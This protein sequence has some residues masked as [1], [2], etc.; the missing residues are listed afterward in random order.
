LKK[1]SLW[2][3]AALML[4]LVLIFPGIILADV[5]KQTK[6]SLEKLLLGKEVKP[7]VE[8]PATKEGLD[9]YIV[10][11]H[12][13][14]VDDR[15]VDL[16]AMSKELKS[17]GVGVEAQQWET[18]TD[19]KVDGDHIEIHLGGGGEGRRGANHANKVGA[20]YLRAGGSRVNF[21]YMAN[22]T[23]RDLQPEAFLNF[24][25]RVLDVSKVQSEESAKG[26][27]TEIRTAIAA[28]TVVEGMTYQMVQMSFGDPEQK[29]INDTTDSTF[30]ETWFYLRNG[31]RW[32]LTFVNGS[33][34]KVQVY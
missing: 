23:D 19:V 33:V 30:S 6:D 14:R 4:I 28:K 15:G 26:F 11:P 13:K 7:L 2:Q 21:R 32:V 1:V 29:K 18:I 17:K 9:V 16:G 5:S 34:G 24:M 8:L 10:P 20:G 3:F 22:V 25:S 27:P 31:H 12:G